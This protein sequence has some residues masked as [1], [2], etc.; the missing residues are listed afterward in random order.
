[1]TQ[2]QTFH[3]KISMILWKN[4]VNKDKQ[5]V[6]LYYHFSLTARMRR[7]CNHIDLRLLSSFEKFEKK[8][9]SN[10]YGILQLL[11]IKHNK[12]TNKKCVYVINIFELDR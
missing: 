11:S 1:M 3:H 5:L 2:K 9:N 8:I 6:D 4:V 7:Y 10:A 12:N